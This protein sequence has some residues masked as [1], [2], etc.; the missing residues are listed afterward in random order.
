[1]KIAFVVPY[2]LP[3][4]G[5]IE[6]YIYEL[7][8]R[9]S[10]D[11][12]VYVFACG[13]GIT[14][15]REGVKVFK[16]RA[17]D[18]QNL[19]FHLKIPYPIPISLIYK[20][21]RFDVDIIHAHGHAFAPSFLA[22]FASK[23]VY[24]PLVLTVHDIG[25]AYQNYLLTR[26]IRPFLDS[27]LVNYAF[28][29]ADAVVAQ[30]DVT[31]TFALRFRPKRIV[32]I[33]QGVDLDRFKPCGMGEY[34][35]FVSRLVPYKGG[36]VFIRAIPEVLKEVGDVK[37]RVIGDGFQR[38][39]LEE[40]AVDLGVGDSVE[41]LGGV[42]YQVVP[43]YLSQA[44]IVLSYFSGLVLLEAAAMR[45]PII[46]TRNKWA[47]DALGNNTL[48]VSMRGPEETANAII[49]LLKNP[50]ERVRI[51]KLA[52]DMVTSERSWD[53]VA[54]RHIDLYDEVLSKSGRR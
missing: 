22:G 53:M 10:K 1:M 32:V 33:P 45:K 13:Q 7:A 37:F 17:I 30:N 12:A 16:L 44:K 34:V 50:D 3:V 52:Y 20:L 41:F 27:T 18:A 24:R 51:A 23:L 35:T 38:S 25:I 2:F 36:E 40:L 43:R 11:H 29:R 6:T 48:F 9:L 31:Y 4:V 5:G 8:R 15:S 49:R 46:T 14:E 21:T 47:K 26:G 39:F 19:P 54:S 28:R 42:P